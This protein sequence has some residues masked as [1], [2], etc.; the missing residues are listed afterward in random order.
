MSKT[1]CPV[2]RAEFNEHAQPVK[3]DI[4]GN[5]SGT[6]ATNLI[7]AYQRFVSQAH[8]H[9]ML[10]YGATITPFGGSFYYTPAH[11][12]ARQTVNAWIRTNNVYDGVIDF[13]A[14][15]R[16]PATPANLLPAYNSSDNLHLS[17]AGYH[18]MADAIDLHLFTR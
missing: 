3:V 10:A 6:I 2:T 17:P 13:D 15:V 1:T 9:H 12:A 14:A 8:D 5:T 18:A 16:D 7:A 11:E 4:G